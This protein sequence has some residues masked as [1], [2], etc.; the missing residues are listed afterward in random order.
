[1][2]RNALYLKSIKYLFIFPAVFYLLSCSGDPPELHSVWSQLNLFDDP[3][4]DAPVESLSLFIQAEDQD[5]VEDLDQLYLI[6]D[7]TF[8]TW[9]IS[10]DQW[11]SYIDQ[12]VTWIGFNGLRAA[13]DGHFAE[14]NYRVLLIDLGG[15]RGEI[16]FYLRN[17]IP[18]KEQ[19]SLPEILYDN[20]NITITS[21]FP[22]F[23]IWFY[24]RDDNLLEKS[25]EITAG[26]HQWNRISKNITRRAFSFSV[27]SEPESGAWGAISGPFYLKN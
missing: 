26:S 6:N 15:E 17:R 20:E 25:R 18:E 5:G 11:V 23:E 12:E 16:D 2:E 13:G 1:M 27:Y 21:D 7:D 22:K 4:Y 19:L 14:G 10:S 24:D 3:S 8:S 9:T